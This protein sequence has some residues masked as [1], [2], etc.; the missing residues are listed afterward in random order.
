MTSN[1]YLI[2]PGL[3]QAPG[4]YDFLKPDQLNIDICLFPANKT[5]VIDFHEFD[6][7]NYDQ[8]LNQYFYEKEIDNNKEYDIIFAHSLGALVFLKCFKNLNF[9]KAYL[10]APPFKSYSFL[11]GLFKKLPPNLKIPS[12]NLPSR[13]MHNYC[14]IR[15][16][17][18]ILRLQTLIRDNINSKNIE[19]SRITIVYDPRDELVRYSDL[20]EKFNYLEY[21]SNDF[22]RHLCLDFIEKTIVKN[23]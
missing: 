4:L 2:I 6:I 14:L 20:F 22:P 15:H 13:R 1:R 23:F 10:I 19:D 21:F 8:I 5:S 16:Y 3:N 11:S 12:L 7:Y 18:S 9:K 17:Q